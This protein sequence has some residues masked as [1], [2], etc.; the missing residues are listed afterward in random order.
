MKEHWPILVILAF[1][2]IPVYIGV[3]RLIY[4]DFDSFI[5]SL[6]AANKQAWVA[7]GFKRAGITM[8]DLISNKLRESYEEEGISRDVEG[9]DLS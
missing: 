9:D 1:A 8:K 3:G 2:N 6:K 4:P 7:F 5:E